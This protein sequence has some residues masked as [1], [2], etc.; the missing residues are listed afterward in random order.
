MFYIWSAIN[1][2][3]WSVSKL[4]AVQFDFCLNSNLA[5]LPIM[6]DKT[7]VGFFH[8]NKYF[9]KRFYENQTLS[10]WF[11]IFPEKLMKIMKK[12]K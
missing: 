3:I 1:Y 2:P 11:L 5:K 10:K 7:D 12:I 4:L 6:D 9:K 8:I